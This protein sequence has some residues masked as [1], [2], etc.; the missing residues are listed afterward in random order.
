MK[1][2]SPIVYY[3]LARDTSDLSNVFLSLFLVANADYSD[4]KLWKL[5]VKHEYIF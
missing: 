5:G 4:K 2:L 3:N 1:P